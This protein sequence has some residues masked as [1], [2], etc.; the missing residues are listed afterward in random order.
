MRRPMRS[1]VCLL[2]DDSAWRPGLKPLGFLWNV[3]LSDVTAPG[4]RRT[5]D[6]RMR[7]MRGGRRTE[8]RLWQ[9]LQAPARSHKTG[10]PGGN[11]WVL[12]QVQGPVLTPRRMLTSGGGR[13][14]RRSSPGLSSWLELVGGFYVYDYAAALNWHQDFYFKN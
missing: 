9:D 3:S 11:L 4:L 8:W 6:E 2:S 12:S 13:S 10:A 5:G 1:K 14:H 7:K